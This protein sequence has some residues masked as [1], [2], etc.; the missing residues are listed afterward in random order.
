MI[1]AY[2]LL[3]PKSCQEADF[4]VAIDASKAGIAGVLLQEDSEGHLR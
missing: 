4:F 1:S 2:V 3:I